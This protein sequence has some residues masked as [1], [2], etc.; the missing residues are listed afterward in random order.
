MECKFVDLYKYWGQK[1]PEGG[2]GFLHIYAQHVPAKLVPRRHPA[3]LVIPG[4]GYSHVSE[5][6]GEPVALRFL[7]RGYCAF[8]LAYSVAPVRFP[9]Q[10]REAA[11]AM[12]YIRQN[13]D[14]LGVDPGMV[15]AI[16]FSAGG[17]LCGMLGTLFDVPEVADIGSAA[18][19]RPNALGLCYPVA[20]SWGH[21][22]EGSFCNLCGE[23]G[24]LRSRLS[25]DRL[26]RPDMPPVYL[27]HTRDDG[28]VPCRNTLILAQAL[29][30]AGVSMAMRLHLHGEH[31]LSTAD[32]QAYPAGRIPAVSPGVT[33]WPEE[34]M[35]FF[36]EI[37]LKVTDWE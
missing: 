5:R 13:A 8:V 24:A 11:M 34:M 25:L 20:V 7:C 26:V 37:G 32:T 35:E 29:E 23:D 19:I 30:S 33:A 10:L 2:A 28:T 9:A 14:A 15:A 3:V 4:G 16:G 36:G 1:R 18:Q 21:T 12:G 22:H 17:H 31:G 27:W 6:E